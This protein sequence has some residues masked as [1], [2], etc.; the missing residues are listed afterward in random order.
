MPKDGTN[1]ALEEIVTQIEDQ[2]LIVSGAREIQ[3]EIYTRGR[4]EG[5][6]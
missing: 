3:K 2:E 4:H 5:V 6:S 1:S